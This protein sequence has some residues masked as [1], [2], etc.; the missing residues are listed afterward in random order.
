M[1]TD[2]TSGRRALRA[3][4][5]IHEH[6]V[7]SG[8]FG[9]LPILYDHEWQQ[10][11]RTA[12]RFELARDKGWMA[13]AE[14]LVSDLDFSAANLRRRLDTFRNELPKTPAQGQIASPRE[15]ADDISA[16]GEEFEDLALDLQEK[17]LSVITAPIELEDVFLGRFRIVLHWEQIGKGPCYDLVAED[18]NHAQDNEDVTHPH[19][20][21]ERLCEGEGSTA[22]RSA[23]KQGRLLDFFT[24]VKQILETYNAGSA[25]V[26]LSR[27]TGGT[28]CYDCGCAI[29]EDE[30]CCCDRCCESIC[31]N[32]RSCC[33]GCGEYLCSGCCRQ[34][35]DCGETSCGPCLNPHPQTKSLVCDSCLNK[36]ETSDEQEPAEAAPLQSEDGGDSSSASLAVDALCLEEA[37]VP[38]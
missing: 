36:G 34:C 13:A 21:H 17:T 29:S 35:T 19:V 38:A 15:I 2:T 25:Y 32:C 31:D 10:L 26:A 8:Q 30:S 11:A 5:Q 18:P 1:T 16:L 7:G 24:L 6:L 9:P 4:V 37:A 27:W 3:A 20:S 12:A 33:E 23:L 22:I 28:D 14:S